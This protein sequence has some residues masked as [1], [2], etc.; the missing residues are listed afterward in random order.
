MSACGGSGGGD[1]SVGPESGNFFVANN[2]SG[3]PASISR[4]ASDFSLFGS[5]S[6]TSNEGLAIDGNGTLYQAADNASPGAIIAV[7][8]FEAQFEDGMPDAGTARVIGGPGTTLSTLDAPKGITVIGSE[9]IVVADFG[10]SVVSSF[11]TSAEG[12]VAPLAV[13]P[14]SAAKP[15]DVAYDASRDILYASLTNGTVDAYDDFVVNGLGVSGPTR[16]ITP[17]NASGD[18]ISTNLHGII[19]DNDRLLLS[20]VGA[21]SAA[22]SSD[23][24]ADGALFLLT[25]VSMANGSVPV[26]TAISGPSTGLGNPVDVIL[27]GDTLYVA[28]KANDAFYGFGNFGSRTGDVG[29][30]VVVAS[31]KA[32][33]LLFLP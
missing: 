18:K 19:F 30:D 1:G 33:S 5:F 32:E 9:T 28:E 26:S 17:A 6:A 13:A 16:T 25:S 21:A 3:G 23:F 20:D 27:V 29:P 31:Q 4:I 2:P 24:A 22:Q 10:A 11:S 14:V 15:W 8:N 7:D 12:D